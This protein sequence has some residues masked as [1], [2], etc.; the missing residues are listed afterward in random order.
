LTVPSQE[1]VNP[2]EGMRTFS[3]AQRNRGAKHQLI[4]EVKDEATAET[5]AHAS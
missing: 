4:G 5:L 2:E 1:V 3:P